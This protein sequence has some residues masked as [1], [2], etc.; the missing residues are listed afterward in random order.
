MNKNIFDNT[1]NDP[2]EV[3]VFPASFAQQR[4]WFLDRLTPGNPIYNVSA[5]LR[6][7]GVLNLSALEKTFNEIIRRHEVLRTNFVML[8]GELMQIIAPSLT[9]NLSVT[10]LTHLS[11]ITQEDKVKKLIFEQAN[12]PFDLAKDPLFRVNLLKISEAEYILLLNFEHI[13]VDGWSIGVL[14]RELR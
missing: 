5:V 2:E 1:L 14:I 12:R 9:S 11:A 13:V 10:D 7:K 3:F 8:E 4:L 6:L